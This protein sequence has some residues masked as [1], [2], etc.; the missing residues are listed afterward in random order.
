MH[1]LWKRML[2]WSIWVCQELSTCFYTTV[3]RINILQNISELTPITFIFV[4]SKYIGIKQRLVMSETLV[5]DCMNCFHPHFF[6]RTLLISNI[7]QCW[8]SAC[9]L[10]MDVLTKL[11]SRGETL[12]LGFNKSTEWSF[13]HF[14]CMRQR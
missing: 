14:Q 12:P 4:C 11:S 1:T 13:W 5:N 8:S 2:S 3:Y 7:L 6:F 9:V 10:G